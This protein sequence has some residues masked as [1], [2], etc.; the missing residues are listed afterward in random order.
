[1]LPDIEDG[2]HQPNIENMELDID[3]L[4][5]IANC[6]NE[7]TQ[8]Q[9][10]EDESGYSSQ[11]SQDSAGGSAPSSP[12]ENAQNP[13]EDEIEKITKSIAYVIINQHGIEAIQDP[14]TRK[15][16]LATMESSEMLRKEKTDDFTSFRERIQQQM[17]R[18]VQNTEQKKQFLF[19]AFQQLIKKVSENQSWRSFVNVV[20]I[21]DLVKTV[22]K[23]SQC[24]DQ[25]LQKLMDE[26]FVNFTKSHYADFIVQ[27]GGYEDLID[28]TEYLKN[29]GAP[30]VPTTITGLALAG[31]G[32]ALVASFLLGRS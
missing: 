7:N 21:V 13:W 6:H 23:S 1:M 9:N 15:I 8:V 20:N 28:Y 31:A 26:E 32:A 5:T 18:H 30:S 29:Y 2:E 16:V 25:Q 22:A 14:K 19:R 10:V 24:Y 12:V 4:E 3:P 11:N 27:S 17:D